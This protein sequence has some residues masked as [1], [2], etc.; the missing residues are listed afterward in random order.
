MPE[1]DEEL[2]ITGTEDAMVKVSVLLSDPHE[3]ATPMVIG[4][5]PLTNGVPEMVPADNVN[6]LGK[7]LAEKE[8]GLLLAV[9]V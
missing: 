1:A 8:V 4:N 6:P 9:I 3:L 5:E 2:V 7:A